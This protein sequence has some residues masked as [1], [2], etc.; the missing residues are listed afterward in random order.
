MKPVLAFPNTKSL[1]LQLVCSTKFG[2]YPKISNEQTWNMFDSDN[3]MVTYAGHKKVLNISD[4]A[5]G[6][7]VFSSERGGF[8]LF[9]VDEE[10]Y[11]ID[12]YLNYNY[13]AALETTTGDID[14]AEND[15]NQIGICDA[16]YIYIYNY[17]AGSFSKAPIDASDF[18]PASLAF[19]DGYFIAGAKG[20]A[21]WRL[22]ALNNGM[23][24]P[25]NAENI[26]LLQAP[27]NVLACI[28]MPNIQ[29]QLFIFGSTVAHCFNNL[30]GAS[31]FPYQRNNSFAIDYG[32]VS[33]STIA[34]GDKFIIWLGGNAKS[35]LAIMYSTGGAQQQISTDGINLRLEQLKNPKNSYGSLIK[36]DG[37]VF[38]QLTFTDPQDNFTIA[39]DFN[40]QKF[41]NVSDNNQNYHEA[42]RIAYFN[43]THYFANFNDGNL[44]E[45]SSNYFT[46]NGKEIPRIIITPPVRLP[47]T[48]PFIGQSLYIL[49][50]QGESSGRYYADPLKYKGEISVAADFPTNGTVIKGDMYKILAPVD[51]NDQTKTNTSQKFGRCDIVWNGTSWDVIQD[52]TSRVD[53]SLSR[54]G[55]VTFGSVVSKNIQKIGNRKNILNYFGLGRANDLTCQ[56]RFYGFEKFVVSNG[57]V[58]IYQ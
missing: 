47:D 33:K 9:I 38:Y 57:E 49:I 53:L 31:L 46:Y 3:F 58:N 34:S 52:I 28:P 26:G 25:A 54:D 10:I 29:G 17:V 22:S 11:V 24:W 27:D 16:Q 23:L 18:I 12:K 20:Q 30:P 45:M 35:G 21:K 51:D 39:Y 4:S 5:K 41:F 6:R 40:T 48:T 37:H 42:R 13:V 55:G 2:R 7:A 15:A 36:L 8:L 44:Y 56:F 14:I 19:Q 50:Q 32:C 43:N 1:P